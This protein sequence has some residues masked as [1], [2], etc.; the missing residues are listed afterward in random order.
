M[1]VVGAPGG[2]ADASSDQDPEATDNANS[3][4]TTRRAEAGKR[5]P[6]TGFL[7][8]PAAGF[9][10]SP[11][12]N[13]PMPVLR[14]PVPVP[15]EVADRIEALGYRRT[16]DEDARMQVILNRVARQMYAE[17]CGDEDAAGK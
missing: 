15:R 11:T 8:L 9:V 13:I 7:P 12:R 4:P 5:S 3:P 17:L 10:L 6:V 16:V 2:V 1:S 14:I